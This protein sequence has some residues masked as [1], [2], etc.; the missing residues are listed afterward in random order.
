LSEFK[1]GKYAINSRGTFS[2]LHKMS[3]PFISPHK[4]RI[5]WYNDLSYNLIVRDFIGPDRN[6]LHG[7]TKCNTESILIEMRKDAEPYI[8]ERRNKR[9]TE[10]EEFLV[11]DRLERKYRRLIRRGFSHE[12]AMKKISQPYRKKGKDFPYDDII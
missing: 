1:D 9:K 12:E 4:K 2:V 3:C 8:N 6:P 7:C 11:R 10:F 5:H